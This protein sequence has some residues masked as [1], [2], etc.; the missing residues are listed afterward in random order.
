MLTANN[1]KTVT[2]DDLMGTPLG[3][4]IVPGNYGVRLLISADADPSDPLQMVG[5]GEMFRL[6][7]Q[8]L[9]MVGERG[10]IVSASI[11][12]RSKP[13]PTIVAMQT[14]GDGYHVIS[15]HYGC[16]TCRVCRL[17]ASVWV[18]GRDTAAGIDEVDH[19][20]GVRT[21]DD[22]AN[23]EWV[24]HSENI[25]RSYSR[26]GR[27]PRRKWTPDDVVLLLPRR[28]GA[29]CGHIVVT[30][31]RYVAQI[32]GSSNVSHCLTY[33]D[34]AGCGDYYVV[35]ISP[36]FVRYLRMPHD[37][38]TKKSENYKLFVTMLMDNV[39]NAHAAPV[40]VI[41]WWAS[42]VSALFDR[43]WDLGLDKLQASPYW[44]S[45]DRVGGA[46]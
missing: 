14:N 16:E 35:P 8:G 45:P 24:N 15:D 43:Y 32:T 38:R 12:A 33:R 37:E 40:G 42:E 41:M 27:R 2:I 39:L 29:G 7:S 9:V 21:N 23:L 20:D 44:Y 4:C 17:V 1:I 3:D 36:V 5:G 11:P 26:P 19:L 25:R 31:A 13:H 6:P 46:A 22:A 28:Y 18:P 34:R 30:E 10:T